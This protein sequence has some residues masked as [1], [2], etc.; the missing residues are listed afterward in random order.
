MA[1]ACEKESMVFDELSNEL[2][3]DR[4]IVKAMVSGSGYFAL[5]AIPN[6]TQC[7]YPDLVIEDWIVVMM[8]MTVAMS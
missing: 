6:S 2:Q 1:I 3:V 7:L 8:M 5:Y 4:A